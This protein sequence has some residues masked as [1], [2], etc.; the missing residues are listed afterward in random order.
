[1]DSK[2]TIQKITVRPID[3][4]ERSQWIEICNQHHYLG[5]KGCFGYS[6]LY[7]ACIDGEW[8]A[9]LSWS[10]SALKIKNRDDWIGWSPS[11]RARR[12][13]LVLNNSRFLILP[14]YNKK[15]FASR[16]LGLNVRRLQQDWQERFRISPVLVETFIDPRYFQGISYLA[17]GWQGIGTTAGFRRVTQGFEKSS[18]PKKILVKLLHRRGLEIL[19]NPRFLDINGKESVVLNCLLW[20]DNCQMIPFLKLLLK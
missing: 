9:L 6:I 16:I 19:R 10:A 5:F 1:M 2:Y 17:S 12:S 15:N 3:P 4:S 11:I 20:K 14:G 18:S 7:C 13:N 8:I